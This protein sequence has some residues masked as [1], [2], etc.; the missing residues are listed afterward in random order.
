MT[1]MQW[2]VWLSSSLF[3]PF[4]EENSCFRRR[5]GGAEFHCS[6]RGLWKHLINPLIPVPL[7]GYSEC[8]TLM[9]RLP[10]DWEN[11]QRS[12]LNPFPRFSSSPV[13]RRALFFFWRAHTHTHKQA[14][15]HVPRT[16]VSPSLFQCSV[17][18][19][20]L[21]YFSYLREEFPALVMIR[22]K[23]SLIK[24]G[25]SSPKLTKE[26]ILMECT[27][28]KKP[29]WFRWKATVCGANCP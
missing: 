26:E 3:L 18:R 19:V 1:E 16:L 25:E 2:M 8:L 6:S 15:K 29:A 5:V 21:S 27:F 13:S 10:H 12:Q 7:V 20:I 17:K 22:H 9:V 23:S 11:T 14:D 24:W 28:C 4:L